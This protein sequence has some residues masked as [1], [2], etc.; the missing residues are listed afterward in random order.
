[1]SIIGNYANE[2]IVL[3]S[4]PLKQRCSKSVMV[5]NGKINIKKNLLKNQQ[6]K[7]NLYFAR[8][9]FVLGRFN[10]VPQMIQGLM[11]SSP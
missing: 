8:N 1:M 4:S 5:S 11:G 2:A 10:V 9:S 3:R 7:C 6:Y